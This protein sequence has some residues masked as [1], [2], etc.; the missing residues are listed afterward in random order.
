MSDPVADLLTRIRNGQR[1]NKRKITALYSNLKKDILEVLK[2]EGFIVDYSISEI[3][4]NIRELTVE[5]KYFKSSP[6]I[7][8]I[9]RISKPGCRVFKDVQTLPSVYNGLGIS[10]IST[11]QGL[12]TDN[13]ART[14]NIGGEVI[15]HV[16]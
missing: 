5:L 3:R 13:D 7:Q 4:K 1:A 15:C 16:F 8:E 12:M 10:I 14:K 11:S 6:V 9:K 2:N